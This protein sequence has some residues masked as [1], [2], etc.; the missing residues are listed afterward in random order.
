MAMKTPLILTIAAA[1]LVLN[2]ASALGATRSEIAQELDLRGYYLE[3][4]AEGNI[5]ELEQFAATNDDPPVYIVSLAA[6]PING[7]DGLA[8]ELRLTV[9]RQGTI[10]VISPTEIGASSDLHDADSVNN[11]VDAALD[12][13]D[14]SFLAGITAFAE[15]LGEPN[16]SSGGG[17]GWIIFALIAVAIVAGLIFFTR[18]GKKKQTGNARQG[19]EKELAELSNEILELSEQVSLANNDKATAHFRAG[20]AAFVELA[21]RIELATTAP[22]FVDIDFELDVAAW[23]MDAAE[24]LING[25]AVPTKPTVTPA[26]I[27]RPKIEPTKPGESAAAQSAASRG[28]STDE[29]LS[30]LGIPQD[31]GQRV[32]RRAATRQTNGGSAATQMMTGVL[33]ALAM[34]GLGRRSHRGGYGYS[35]SRGSAP[36]TS[37]RSSRRSNRAAGRARRSRG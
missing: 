18:R 15:A 13:L 3:P 29:F 33:G 24:A 31:S 9:D 11:A 26:L 5:N 6:D 28:Q 8:D 37:R 2:A 23:H 36:R 12:G 17:S 7:A 32:Q 22:E 20:S 1:L 34:G 10:L 19:L 16:T 4:E 21:K 14:E 30:S 25:S 35:G 27:A